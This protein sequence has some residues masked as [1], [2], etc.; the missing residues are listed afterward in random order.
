M[1]AHPM[2]LPHVGKDSPKVAALSPT[3]RQVYPLLY[4]MVD[5]YASDQPVW[6]VTRYLV[7][8]HGVLYGAERSELVHPGWRA[9]ASHADLPLTPSYLSAVSKPISGDMTIQALLRKPVRM[10]SMSVGDL[11]HHMEKTQ[12]GRPA[13][14]A[15]HAQKLLQNGWIVSQKNIQLTDTGQALLQ[16]IRESK[17]RRFNA[18]FS[19]AMLADLDAIEDGKL[20]TGEGFARWLMPKVAQTAEQWLQTQSIHGDLASL[21]YQA[22]DELDRTVVEWPAGAVP[23]SI[24]PEQLLPPICPEREYRQQLNQRAA[25]MADDWLMLTPAE[26]IERR[27]QVDA[28]TK[29]MTESQWKAH[30]TFD[31]LHR[32][33]VGWTP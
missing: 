32:W 9:I 29:N 16:R 22:R 25:D 21:A 30:Y 15:S 8:I 18:D 24:D 23:K 7:R 28:E 31:L 3:A 12:L 6:A 11:I 19:R 27:I 17:A 14:Y 20:S 26:R 33:Y 4:D 5:A 2:I 13:T 10:P 1:Q